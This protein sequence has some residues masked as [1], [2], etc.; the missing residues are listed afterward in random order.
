MK[1]ILTILLFTLLSTSMAFAMNTA[2]IK[3]HINGNS[4]NN[5]YFLCFRTVGCF[6]IL[7]AQRGESYPIIRPFNVHQIFLSDVQDKLLVRQAMPASC[8]TQVKLGQTLSVYGTI[9]ATHSGAAITGLAC[10]IN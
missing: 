6:S 10:K 4:S 3:L 2:T 5:K 7:D 9:T 8:Q 1:K